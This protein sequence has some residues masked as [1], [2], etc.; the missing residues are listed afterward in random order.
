MKPHKKHI[1]T[2]PGKITRSVKSAD[3]DKFI[4]AGWEEV[5]T[6]KPKADTILSTEEVVQENDNTNQGDTQ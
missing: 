4:A 2:K 1:I 6:K 5:K 3:L